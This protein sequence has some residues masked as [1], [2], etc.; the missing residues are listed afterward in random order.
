MID[1]PDLSPGSSPWETNRT[2]RTQSSG[3]KYESARF[4][5]PPSKLDQN[6]NHVYTMIKLIVYRFNV[7]IR[8]P[9]ICLFSR[10]LPYL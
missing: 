5:G 3:G 2:N 6:T 10:S 4:W 8:K 7:F 1:P 9:W